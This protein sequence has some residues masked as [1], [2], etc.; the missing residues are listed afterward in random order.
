MHMRSS[1]RVHETKVHWAR[2]MRVARLKK[3]KSQKT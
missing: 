1:A 3:W 2:G